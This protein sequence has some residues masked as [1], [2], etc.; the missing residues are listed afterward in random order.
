MNSK[1][2]VIASTRDIKSFI[3]NL[4]IKIIG[5]ADLSGLTRMPAGIKI[6]LSELFKKYP[7]AIVMGAQYGKISKKTSG[8]EVVLFLERIVYDVMEYIEQK[9]YQYLVIHPEDEYDPDN[10]MGLLSLKVLAKQAG[11]GWQGRSLLVVSPEYGPVHRLIAILTNMHLVPDKP[12]K[13]ECGDCTACIDS[14]PKK[15]L[16]LTQFDDHPN[17]RRE[18]LNI[19]TC[20]GDN[21]CIVCILKCP[22]LKTNIRLKPTMINRTN[23]VKS[24]NR[25]K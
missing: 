16:S 11:I 5:I 8:K 22:Y 19:K 1:E 3:H 20:L 7:Y 24:L 9:G 21:G 15:S 6:D 10:R 17:S 12:I 2:K 14:C 18:V 13:N 4:G 25:R 23:D